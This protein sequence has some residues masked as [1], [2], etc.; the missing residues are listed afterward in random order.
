MSWQL[1]TLIAVLVF[2]SSTVL[3]RILMK[4]RAF[5]PY[6][7]TIVMYGLAGI[8]SLMLSLYLGRFH[9][10]VTTN[11]FLLF[12]PLACFISGGS[13]LLF[14]GLQ[15]LGASESSIL[16]SVQ[17]LWVVIGAFILL[18]EPFSMM[19]VAGTIVIMLGICIALWKRN[20]LTFG[21][22]SLLV[23]ISTLLYS[24]SDLLSLYFVRDFDPLSLLV[25]IS[26]LPVIVL[27]ILKPK[28][29]KKIPF[30]F[31]PRRALVI[32]VLSLID[33]VGTLSVDM[34]YQVGRNAAQIGPLMGTITIVSVLIAIIFLK[35]RDNMRN[36]LI[37]ALIVVVGV[38]MLL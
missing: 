9:Y 37:G 16:K 32:V 3:H 11:Q 24:S 26:F 30:Y 38:W 5:D 17:N 18:G 29:V 10:Q 1:L 25:Y 20:Q 6:T 14:K 28:T 36:K 22:G 21:R 15:T 7:Q 2:S 13:V 12:I 23:I 19:K 34:A 27:L 8:G 35:E 4:D 31:K 33:I